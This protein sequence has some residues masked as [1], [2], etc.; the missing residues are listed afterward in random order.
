MWIQLTV[1][2][3][4]RVFPLSCDFCYPPTGA[5]HTV[6]LDDTRAIIFCLLDILWPGVDVLLGWF[7]CDWVC[8]VWAPFILVPIVTSEIPSSCC[9]SPSMVIAP[10][11]S[12]CTSSCLLL[13][14]LA[15]QS[16]ISM[17]VSFRWVGT[18]VDVMPST[19]SASMPLCGPLMFLVLFLVIL[20]CNCKAVA[21]WVMVAKKSFLRWL[22]AR[23]AS[24]AT[25]ALGQHS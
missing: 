5:W 11:T 6:L 25:L 18:K 14:V 19:S 9:W 3:D 4:T 13:L 20:P 15:L 17:A 7:C 10:W 1:G 23:I 12:S 2:I 8:L 22:L 24:L 16:W 21:R